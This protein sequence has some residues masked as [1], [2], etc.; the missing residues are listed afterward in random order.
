ME[1]GLETANDNRSPKH[2][3]AA[4]F[5]KSDLFRELRSF[6]E[7]EARIAALPKQDRGEAFEVFAEAYLST[8]KQIQAAEVW[9]YESVPADIKTKMRLPS[10][11]KGVDGVV[12]HAIG[13]YDVYQAKF[14]K[15]RPSLSWSFFNDSHS[16]RGRLSHE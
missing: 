4:H 7:F 6:A 1:P 3:R 8:Q 13:E 16:Q 9:P 2:P 10:K 12:Q 5:Q 14:R 15:G 11:D